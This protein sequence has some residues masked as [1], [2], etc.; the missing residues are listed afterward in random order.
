MQCIDFIL[1]VWS[2]Y[3]SQIHP[4]SMVDSGRYV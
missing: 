1:K 4:D 2:K 3:Y